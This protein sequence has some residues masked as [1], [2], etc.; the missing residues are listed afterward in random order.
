MNA[1]WLSLGMIFLAELGDKTQLVAL[2][3]AAR[4]SAKVVLGGIFFAT[5][6]VHVFS[7]GIGWLMG[8][9]LPAEWVRFIAGL[10]FIGFGFWTLRGDCL[11]EEECNDRNHRSPF[12]LVFATFFLAELGDKT[13]LSTVTLA[14]TNSFIPVWIGSTLGMVLSDGLA[15]MAG[16]VLGAKLPERVVK[17]GAAVIFFGFGLLSLIQGGMNLPLYVWIISGVIVFIMGFLFLGKLQVKRKL[18]PDSVPD[19][20][21]EAAATK[22]D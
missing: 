10:S 13:M 18:A 3:L 15:I 6:A 1:F 20:S 5:L 11:D 22:S 14:A 21:Q 8:G 16:K 2:T 12:W 19:F 4:Y 9:L 17:T 7:A